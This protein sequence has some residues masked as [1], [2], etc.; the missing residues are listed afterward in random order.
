[1][2]IKGNQLPKKFKLLLVIYAMLSK[3]QKVLKY[4]DI[5]VKA[6]KK[7]PSDFHLRGYPQ[8]PDTGDSSQRPL[9][10]LRREGFIQ[11]HNKFITLTEKGITFVEKLK[12]TKPGPSKSSERFSRDITN[13]IE[14]IKNTEAFQL[15]SIGQKEQ[16]VDSDFFA[17]LG[18]TVRAERTD[19]R[20]R[21]RTIQDVIEAIKINDE[22]KVFIDLHNYLL[23]RFQE[24]IKKKLSIGYPRRNE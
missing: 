22:Y 4:E 21:V 2:K 11:V 12:N 18:T 17:Y 7:Y 1:V 9:Y 20:S 19:F 5:F 23:G 13:E 15:F 10:T 16:I 14:R 24:T 8:F 6:F 3:K